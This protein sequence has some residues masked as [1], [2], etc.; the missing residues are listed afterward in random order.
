MPSICINENCPDIESTGLA[1]VYK[2]GLTV[3]PSCSGTLKPVDPNA[4]G[5]EEDAEGG[6]T[7]DTVGFV[8]DRNLLPVMRSVL[9][10][11]D[12]PFVVRNEYD[13]FASVFGAVMSKLGL[14]VT[15][16]AILV[17][18]DRVEEARTLLNTTAEVTDQPG[19]EE[20]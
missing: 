11:A 8:T 6:P 1:G 16:P 14:K 9:Q 18:S 17:P 4:L 13:Q 20:E 19:D 15:A 5:P 3:C 2:D 12:I 7:L 10:A